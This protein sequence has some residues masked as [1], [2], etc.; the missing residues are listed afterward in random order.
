MLPR[1]FPAT[2]EASHRR[3]GTSPATNRDPT[4]GSVS[5]GAVEKAV[6]GA[7]Y[8]ELRGTTDAVAV[9]SKSAMPT[10]PCTPMV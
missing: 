8:S 4:A 6:G 1:Q 2:Q 5:E 7:G 3:S 10:R 9:A